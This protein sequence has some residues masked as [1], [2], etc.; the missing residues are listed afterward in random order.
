MLYSTLLAP[1]SLVN[2]KVLLSLVPFTNG[3]PH[4]DCILVQK[5]ENLSIGIEQVHDLIGQLSLKP[6]QEQYKV[7]IIDQAHELTIPAQQALLKTIEEPPENTQIIL[8]T[9]YRTK[10]LPT[11]LSRC[12]VLPIDTKMDIAPE[13]EETN[14]SYEGICQSSIGERIKLAQEIGKDRAAATATLYSLLSQLQHKL[15]IS[16]ASKPKLL[17]SMKYLILALEY[18]SRNANVKLVI[19]DLLFSF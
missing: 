9:P 7:A 14:L 10:L 19:E 3:K 6:Y 11:I 16:D 1:F 8:V 2:E 15:D 18:L 17:H 12:M 5:G 13:I 4:P